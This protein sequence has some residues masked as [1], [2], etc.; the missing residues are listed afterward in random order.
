MEKKS[1][2]WKKIEK[3]ERENFAK[4]GKRR[5]E[6]RNKIKEDCK[7]QKIYMKEKKRICVKN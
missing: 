1:R 3:Y 5:K 7:S 6:F 2:K 4:N